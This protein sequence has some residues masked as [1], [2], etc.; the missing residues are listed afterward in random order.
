MSQADIIKALM[1]KISKNLRVSMPATIES[2][3]YKTQKASVKIDMRELFEDSSSIDYPIISNVPV[4]FPRSGGASLTMPVIRGDSCLV[5]FMDRDITDWLAGKSNVVPETIRSH[6]LNDAV[7]VMGLSPFTKGSLAENNTDVLLHYNGSDIRLKPDGLIDIHSAK[8]VNI[9]TDNI[10]INC[11]NATITSSEDIVA[12]CRNLNVTAS[13][14]VNIN[15]IN[16][17]VVATELASIECKNSTMT[18]TENAKI[19]CA[20]AVVNATDSIKTTTLM[21][22]QTGNMKVEGDIEITGT[23]TLTGDTTCAATLKGSTVQTSSGVHLQ[24]HTHS[25]IDSVG[26]AATPTT[27]STGGAT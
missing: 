19:D 26:E 16:S 6:T 2:Y 27:K 22:T 8:E 15:C 11:T 17:K 12:T 13:E 20:T 25:Y 18:I 9:K 10:I 21:F 7:A 4:V 3:D 14:D 5:F 24:S 23:S 1:S